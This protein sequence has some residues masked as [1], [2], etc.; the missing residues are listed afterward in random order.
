MERNKLDSKRNVNVKLKEREEKAR[1][2]AER[3]QKVEARRVERARNLKEG[4]LLKE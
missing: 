4:H 2:T 1:L 3:K